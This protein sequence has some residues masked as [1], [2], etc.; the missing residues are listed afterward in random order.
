MSELY[1]TH[2]RPRGDSETPDAHGRLASSGF[3]RTRRSGETLSDAIWECGYSG[4]GGYGVIVFRV[5]PIDCGWWDLVVECAGRG[6]NLG[7]VQTVAEALDLWEH[8]RRLDYDSAGW[9]KAPAERAW[10]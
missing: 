10:T 3:V 5:M 8:L 1:T 2:T 9:A 4:S 7:V 6:V